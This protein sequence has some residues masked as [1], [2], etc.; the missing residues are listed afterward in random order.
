RE[1]VITSIQNPA[2]YT[3]ATNM[4]ALSRQGNEQTNSIVSNQTSVN[5]RFT[6]GGLRHS[7]NA[8]LEITSQTFDTPTLGGLGTVAPVSIYA[9]K[10]NAPI[11]GFALAETGASSNAQTHTI[12]LYAFDAVDL[13]SRWQVNGGLRWERYD[14]TFKATGTNGVATTDERAA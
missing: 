11:A 3:P 13:T 1:A 5:D 14:T 7:A 9:P 6:T 10:P 8:G 4:L 12:A 2:A